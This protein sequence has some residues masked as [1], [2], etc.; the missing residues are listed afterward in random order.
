MGHW[1]RRAFLFGAWMTIGTGAL[2]ALTHLRPPPPP[3]GPIGAQLQELARTHRL[4]ILGGEGPMPNFLD[5]FGITFS[6][7]M[8]AWGVTSLLLA[9]RCRS[10]WSAMRT[11]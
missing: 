3:D 2:H 11:A 1:P 4:H 7:L 6:V 10:E 5:G 9:R 8:L